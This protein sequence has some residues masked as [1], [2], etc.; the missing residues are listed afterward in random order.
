MKNRFDVTDSQF[1][2]ENVQK[3]NCSNFQVLP[4][5]VLIFCVEFSELSP[6][7]RD[8]SQAEQMHKIT[9]IPLKI[10]GGVWPGK[11]HKYFIKRKLN[12]EFQICFFF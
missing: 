8:L 12:I 4:F 10:R 7:T 3:D 1:Y 2:K 5:R 11:N 9:S 6:L